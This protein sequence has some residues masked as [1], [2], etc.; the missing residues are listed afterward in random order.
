MPL[1]FVFVDVL[2]LLLSSI[3]FSGHATVY[4]YIN[5]MNYVHFLPMQLIL[6]L[7]IMG[8][9]HIRHRVIVGMK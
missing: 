1:V 3:E 2:L 5:Q 6:L 9:M 4:V 8:I 7:W